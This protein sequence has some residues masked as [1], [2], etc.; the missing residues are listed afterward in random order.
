MLTPFELNDTSGRT[1][2]YA[3]SLAKKKRLPVPALL[4]AA[5]HRDLH[6]PH[7]GWAPNSPPPESSHASSEDNTMAAIG[8]VMNQPG[9]R[10]LL[11]TFAMWAV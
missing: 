3:P 8:M 5:P 11:L 10:D 4:L 1:S 2:Q 6:R 9:A 7:L